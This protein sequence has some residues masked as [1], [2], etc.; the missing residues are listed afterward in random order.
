MEDFEKNIRQLDRPL[1]RFFGCL[2]AVT[3]S[4]IALFI[5][6]LAI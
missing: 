1:D 3:L 4:L 2:I 5:L 6:A